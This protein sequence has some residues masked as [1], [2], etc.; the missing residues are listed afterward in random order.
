MPDILLVEDNHSVA[1][2]LKKELQDCGYRVAVAFSPDNAN[3]D[4]RAAAA[5]LVLVNGACRRASG[6]DVYHR[7]RSRCPDSAVM[8]YLLESWKTVDVRWILAAVREVLS[9]R[10]LRQ[11]RRLSG[12]G[13]LSQTGS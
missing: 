5:D 6:W 4:T 13:S 11:A 2:L 7:L 12:E 10:R 1:F 9:G 8:L 3:T